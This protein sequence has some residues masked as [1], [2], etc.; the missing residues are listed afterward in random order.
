MKAKFILILFAFIHSSQITNTLWQHDLITKVSGLNY[1]SKDSI[2]LA[3]NKGI[4]TNVDNQDGK[5]SWKKNF[6]YNNEYDIV[7]K[8]ECK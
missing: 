2:L 1:I 3:S 4:L 6:I 8:D 5:I 7:S